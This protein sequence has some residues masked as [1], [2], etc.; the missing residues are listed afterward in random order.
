MTV[1]TLSAKQTED[2]IEESDII[3]GNW[4]LDVTGVASARPR[5]LTTCSTAK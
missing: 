2:V 3:N 5:V 1:D 4:K